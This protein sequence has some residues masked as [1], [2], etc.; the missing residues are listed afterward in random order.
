MYAHGSACSPERSAYREWLNHSFC[1]QT[2]ESKVVIWPRDLHRASRNNWST[3]VEH[4]N[5][6][7]NALWHR[8]ILTL[9]T[10]HNFLADAT[11]EKHC[12]PGLLGFDDKSDGQTFETE[13]GSCTDLGAA[14]W[15]INCAISS[16]EVNKL[17]LPPRICNKNNLTTKIYLKREALKKSC[18]QSNIFEAFWI[19]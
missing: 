18:L 6:D 12:M 14:E 10:T 8:L 3:R 1:A 13:S 2:N 11:Y 15:V 4:N 5:D 7:Y 9:D 19:S 16:I 17:P